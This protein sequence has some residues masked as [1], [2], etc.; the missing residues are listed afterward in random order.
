[1]HVRRLARKRRQRREVA[2]ELD[3]LLP[4]LR[5]AA[6]VDKAAALAADAVTDVCDRVAFDFCLEAPV[7][8]E[9]RGISYSLDGR[10]TI[11]LQPWPLAVRGV[12]GLV[13][14]YHADGYP[15]RL[16]PVVV[17]YEIRAST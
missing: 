2:A 17:Q 12:A 1:M 6:A 14:A 10:G 13:Y 3:A 7:T 8:N 4:E 11:R 16:D 5:A 9:V 15:E